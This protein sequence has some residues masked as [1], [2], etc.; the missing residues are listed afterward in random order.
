MRVAHGAHGIVYEH[1][2]ERHKQHRPKS[3]CHSTADYAVRY[4]KSQQVCE[5]ARYAERK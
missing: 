3:A 4:H 1:Y 2:H 5:H